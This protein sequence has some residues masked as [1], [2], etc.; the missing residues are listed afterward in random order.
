M[1]IETTTAKKFCY[2]QDSNPGKLVI[3]KDQIDLYFISIPG[4]V[5][6]AIA[7]GWGCEKHRFESR[8]S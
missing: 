1:E 3:H 6:L 2:S 8:L 4:V 5:V 7:L